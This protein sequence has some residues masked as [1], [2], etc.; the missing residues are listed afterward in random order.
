MIGIDWG[1]SNLRAYR[2]GADGGVLEARSSEAGAAALAPED[3]EPVLAALLAGWTGAGDPIV[4]AGM[5]GRRGGWREVPYLACPADPRTLARSVLTLEAPFGPCF[6]VPGLSVRDSN[7]VGDVMRG[8]ETQI[9]GARIETG[10]VILPGTHTKWARVVEGRI[11]DFA[12]AMTG[13]LYRLL[14]HH[15]LLGQLAVTGAPFAAAAFRAGALRALEAGGIERIL[16]SA[17]ADVLLGSLEPEAVESYLSG[18]LIG[19]EVAALSAMLDAPPVLIGG[20]SLRA[21]Y[22]EVLALAGSPGAASLDGAEAV[23]RGLWRIGQELPFGGSS[24]GSDGLAL[25][26]GRSS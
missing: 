19:G 7:G 24:D 18:V 10:T 4:L 13:E 17:R 9:L 22:A 21:R 23:A 12:T 6:L 15:S 1:S 14:R 26:M 2:F 16:F 8:E 3:F 25:G 20:E 11:I 5:V